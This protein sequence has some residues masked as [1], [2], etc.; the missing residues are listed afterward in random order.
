MSQ[1]APRNNNK[2]RQRQKRSQ[3]NGKRK[4]KD[5]IRNGCP[6]PMKTAYTSAETALQSITRNGNAGKGWGIYECICGWVHVTSTPGRLF[7]NFEEEFYRSDSYVYT[8][9][10]TTTYRQA[11]RDRNVKKESA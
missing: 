8:P 11:K 4:K 6:T 7:R 3:I 5:Q 10:D 2:A 9:V 1:R